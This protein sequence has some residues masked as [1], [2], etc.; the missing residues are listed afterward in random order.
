MTY[1]DEK[2]RRII[3]CRRVDPISNP[4][5]SI[6]STTAVFVNGVGSAES[7]KLI[8]SSFKETAWRRCSFF[9]GVNEGVCR[10]VSS[11]RCL[12]ELRRVLDGIERLCQPRWISYRIE[13]VAG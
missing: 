6:E 2:T 10:S 8:A 1:H 7:S 4:I 11:K 12:R 5:C 3:L 9:W 13:D